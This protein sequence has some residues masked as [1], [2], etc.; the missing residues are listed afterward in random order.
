MQLQGTLTA[1]RITAAEAQQ[2]RAV[3]DR[4]VKRLAQEAAETAAQ[5]QKARLEADNACKTLARLAAE[6]QARRQQLTAVQTAGVE[7]AAQVSE[8]REHR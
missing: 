2:E 3:L 6:S 4:D 5:A 8:W 1:A 7:L